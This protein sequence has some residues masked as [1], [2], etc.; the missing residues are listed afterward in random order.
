MASIKSLPLLIKCPIYILTYR[1]INYCF[2]CDY[3]AGSTNKGLMC[4]YEEK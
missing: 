4:I 3:Y 2:K 1:V